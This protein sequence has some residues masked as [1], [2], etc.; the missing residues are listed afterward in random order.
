MKLTQNQK[1]AIYGSALQGATVSNSMLYAQ[2]VSPMSTDVDAAIKT[3]LELIAALEAMPD[4]ETEQP[5]PVNNASG[6]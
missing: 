4:E 6:H 3:G 1:V 5:E 2:G